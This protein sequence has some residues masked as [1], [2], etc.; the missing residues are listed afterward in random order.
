MLK[1]ARVAALCALPLPATAAALQRLLC[2]AYWL[3]ESIIEYAK[4]AA[5][6]QSKLDAAFD[7]RS[8]K[9]RFAE[10]LALAW[11]PAEEPQYRDFLDCVATSTKLAFSSETATDDFATGYLQRRYI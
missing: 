2:G 5:P 4:H 10:G 8:R 7:G 9:Q 11:T 1:R 3:R 6:L